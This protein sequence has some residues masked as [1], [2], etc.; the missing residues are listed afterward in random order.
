MIANKVSVPI[1]CW[2]DNTELDLTF[3]ESWSVRQC[4]MNGHNAPA[5][6]DDEIRRRLSSPHGTIPLR[7]L[8]VG[9]KR[10]VILFDDLIRPTPTYRII[11]SVLEELH[12]AGISDG[13]IRFVAAI[14]THGPM[15][16]SEMVQK[17]G[18]DIVERF[19]V[20]NHNIYDN[21]VK[22][23]VTSHGTPVFINRE[24][25]SC[26][27]KLGIGG[28]IPYYAQHVYNG[29]G[30]IILPGVSG[31]ETIHDY[32]VSFHERSKGKPLDSRCEEG[33]PPYRINLEEAARLAG[34]DFKVDLVQNNR[35]EV[36]GLFAGDFVDT[37]RAASKWAR[38]I[39][40]TEI[41]PPS[42]VVILNTYP[43]ED[44]PMKGLWVAV[45]SVKPGGDVVILSHS[46]NGLSHHH[47]LFGKF[48][49]DYGGPGY[50]PGR[51]FTVG[52]AGRII[53]CTPYPSRVDVDSY[54]G[55]HV[56][57]RRTWNETRLLLETGIT[58]P[59]TVAVYPYGGIQMAQPKGD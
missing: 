9:K 43:K 22:V 35:K 14:G 59:A 10:I 44:Q 56:H 31:M 45:Q 41:A 1:A 12:A 25:A 39:Y 49:T 46:A 8:A 37:H 18:A 26:D 47:H 38:G 33:V 11:P 55:D 16:R 36:V 53:F 30:K 13:Q 27:L 15:T 5:L 19:P 4:T 48:G 51:H 3:P 40:E 29:G 17:L 24:V 7:E 54:P 28:V 2:G 23:G 34:L 50:S 58:G 32:H 57:F 21:V 52:D 6:T 42:D 20:Y